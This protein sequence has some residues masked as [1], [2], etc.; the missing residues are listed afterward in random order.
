MHIGFVSTQYPA[1]LR[2]SVYGGFKRMGMFIEALAKLGDLN[3]LFYVRPEVALSPAFIAEA[4]EALAAHYGT[5]LRLDLCN[6]APV[7]QVGGRWQEYVAPALSIRNLP[8]YRQA[9]GAAQAAAAARL[10][11][12]RPDILFVHRL[13]GMVPVLLSGAARPPTW[14]DLDDIE[15]VSYSRSV[16]EPPLW[17]GKRLQYLRVPLLKRW[18]RRAMEASRA[19]FVCSE[20]DRAYLESRGAPGRVVT[21]PNAVDMP[22]RVPAP[23]QGKVM[24]FLGL[25]SFGPNSA[26]ADHLVRDIWPLVH[27]AVPDAR[28]VVAGARPELLAAYQA[29]PPG[30][31]FPGFVADLERLYA[32]VALVCCP[33]RSGSGTRIKILEAAAWGRPVVSTTLGAEGLEFTDGAEIL[34]RDD[35][36]DFAEACIALL[37]DPNRACELARRAR[38]VVE[39]KYVRRVVVDRIAGIIGGN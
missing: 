22:P 23:A 27:R 4:R 1:D 30:V 38:A 16:A 11:D 35:P 24:L 21:V 31:T 9:A 15:H 26:A 25:L 17:P 28:L 37:Q 13:T 6:L 2:T 34:L 7:A 20:P 39:Q 18:E 10:L 36:R 33:I 32:E 5:G 3:M 12:S 8:P 29:P 19:T 14:F